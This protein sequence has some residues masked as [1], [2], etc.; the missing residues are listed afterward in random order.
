MEPN[1]REK[2]N[3]L[4]S[5]ATL[6]NQLQVAKQH[7]FRVKQIFFMIVQSLLLV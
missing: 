4:F 1:V 7:N 6:S 3:S 2:T 5:L